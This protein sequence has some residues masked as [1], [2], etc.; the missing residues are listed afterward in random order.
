MEGGGGWRTEAGGGHIEFA[1]SGRT[2]ERKPG[3]KEDETLPVK[4]YCL[5]EGTRSSQ[6]RLLVLRSAADSEHKNKT[7]QLLLPLN[8]NSD[9]HRNLETL[10]LHQV[11][12][13]SDFCPN[14][15][16]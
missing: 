13:T 2:M 15:V 4:C 9:S 14:L 3:R 6:K 1:K 8:S 10:I 7:L 11:T 12:K 16:H 5:C